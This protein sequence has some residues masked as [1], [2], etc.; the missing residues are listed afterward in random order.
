MPTTVVS[1][2]S[3]FVILSLQPSQLAVILSA[4]N[5]SAGDAASLL[6]PKFLIVFRWAGNVVDL[7]D[8]RIASAHI[9]V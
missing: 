1:A 8:R 4:A 3:V 2:I 5:Q 9:L 7:G 6:V